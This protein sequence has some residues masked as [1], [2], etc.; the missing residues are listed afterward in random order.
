MPPELSTYVHRVGRTARAGASGV[1]VT[2]VDEKYRSVMKEAV[3]RAKK[4]VKSRVV[5][6]LTLS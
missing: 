1:S 2:L 3:K 4:N 5:G 6:G